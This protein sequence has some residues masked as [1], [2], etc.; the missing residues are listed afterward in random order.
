[1][2][3]LARSFAPHA[4]LAMG[5]A[6]VILTG[7]IDLSVG[8]LVALG[9]MILATTLHAGWPL[10]AAVLA[11][12]VPLTSIGFGHAF[13]VRRVRVPA[14][15]ATLGTF[16]MARS[17]AEVANEGTQLTLE[18][19]RWFE[20]IYYG[21]WAGLPVP[22][23]VA[24]GVLAAATV[25]TRKTLAGR[26]LYAVGG[27]ESASFLAGVPVGRT[28]AFAYGAA[29]ACAALAALLWAAK[30]RQGDPGMARS[31]ELYAIAAAVIGGTSLRGGRGSM[32]GVVLGAMVIQ[33]LYTAQIQLQ[34]YIS[35]YWRDFLLGFV[36][37]AAVVADALRRKD[38]AI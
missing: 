10:G 7:G 18:A 1:M 31:Y 26:R 32:I 13:L 15:V 5:E 34:E 17:L 25:V 16:C 12:F 8:A 3:A 38:A 27:S 37:V 4:V 2:E 29:G 24:L 20:G 9:S 28:L 11:V 14:F 21:S 22:L 35:T 30:T 36:L 23:W 19:P 33:V 6:L